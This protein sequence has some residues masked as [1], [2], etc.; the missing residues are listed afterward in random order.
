MTSGSCILAVILWGCAFERPSRFSPSV[1]K[2]A[3]V[4]VPESSA[5]SAA[6]WPLELLARTDPLGFLRHC[7][8][9]YLSRIRDYTCKFHMS[10]REEGGLS[11]TQVIDIRFREHPYSVDMI[12]LENPRGAKRISYVHDRWVREGRQLALVVPSGV[13]SV[14][15]PGGVRLD[16]HGR[17]FR[18][19]STRSVDQFGFRKTIERAI[20]LCEQA[21]G[22]PAFR[23]TYAGRGEF[24]GRP[25]YMLER[26]L[27]FTEGDDTYPD[28]LAVFYID[29]EWLTPTAVRTYADDAKQ[30]Q[31][32]SFLTTDVRYNIGLIDQDFE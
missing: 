2:E 9:E 31:L 20:A 8:C 14:L 12:W 15:L 32:G 6:G 11:D 10:E 23:L 4:A 29:L 24:E 21:E 22:D 5:R 13:G 7:R 30:T 3:Q 27:P 28:R 17:E 18:R 16:I 25:H 19:A 26:R 1:A